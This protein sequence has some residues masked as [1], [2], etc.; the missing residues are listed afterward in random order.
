MAEEEK[1]TTAV[2][3]NVPK[4]YGH[5]CVDINELTFIES[6]M[7]SLLNSTLNETRSASFWARI[8]FIENDDVEKTRLEQYWPPIVKCP[9]DKPF[10]TCRKTSNWPMPPAP[11]EDE[12]E[13]GGSLIQQQQSQE[14]AKLRRI[15]LKIPKP[16]SKEDYAKMMLKSGSGAS[17]NGKDKGKKGKDKG[18]KKGKKG[19]KDAKKAPA[20][21]DNSIS[22]EPITAENVISKPEAPDALRRTKSFEL[23]ATTLTH[24]TNCSL[25][26]EKIEGMYHFQKIYHG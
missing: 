19:N 23:N 22:K 15:T 21:K 17:L 8:G 9:I 6:E 2:E 13:D 12:G 11:K 24:L 25:V 4:E 3:N 14:P 16:T 1:M 5:L 26:I 7:H 10:T 20:V 18:K